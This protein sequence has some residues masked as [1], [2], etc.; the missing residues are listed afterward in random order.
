M[1]LMTNE[2]ATYLKRQLPREQTPHERHIYAE[3]KRRGITIH[4]RGNAFW[5]FGAGV[6]LLVSGLDFVKERDLEANAHRQW[7]E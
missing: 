1:K 2:Q 3:A 4:K 7:N 6:D 5:L